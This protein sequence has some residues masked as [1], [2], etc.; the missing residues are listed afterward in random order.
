[1]GGGARTRVIPFPLAA[2]PAEGDP[3]HAAA[4]AEIRRVLERAID[5][6]PAPF[7]AAFVLRVVEQM[8]VEET[9]A[10]LGVP[11]ETVKT[12]VH[13]AKRRLRE[14][15]DERLAPPLADTL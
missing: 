15:L 11:E 10:C 4:R 13:R 7:R 14:A 3:E 9:A 12:R 5:D 1:M 2:Q 6:L 8:S